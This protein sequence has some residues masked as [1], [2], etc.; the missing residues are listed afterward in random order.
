[1]SI[2]SLKKV[3]LV[4]IAQEKEQIATDLQTKL[5]CMHVATLSQA[6]K[7]KAL[8]KFSL[9]NDNKKAIRYL[10]TAEKKDE[11]IWDREHFDKDQILAEIK[12]NQDDIKRLAQERKE[13]LKQVEIASHW[14]EFTFPSKEE[15]EGYQLWFYRVAHGVVDKI[16]EGIIW[17]AVYEDDAGYYVVVLS[18]DEPCTHTMPVKRTDLGEKPLAELRAELANIENQ[19]EEQHNKHTEL[20]KWEAMLNIDI[21]VIEDADDMSKAIRESLILEDIFALQGWVIKEDVVKVEKFAEEKGLVFMVEEPTWRDNPPT[22]LKNNDKLSVG[23]DLVSF[24][25]TPNYKE[26]DPSITV[27]FSFAFFF[28]MIMADAGYGLVIGLIMAWKWKA[29]GGSAIGKRLRMLGVV[30]SASC[31]AYGAVVGSYFGAMPDLAMFKAM[32]LLEPMNK[33]AM[34]MLAILTGM[35]HIAFANL[36]AAKA[37]GFNR[38]SSLGLLGWVVFIIGGCGLYIG[39]S[40]DI[41]LGIDLFGISAYQK[42]FMMVGGLGLGMILFF[43]STRPF[44]S[45]GNIL[46]RIFDGIVGLTGLSKVFGDILSYLRLFALGLSSAMLASTFN[47][48]AGSAMDGVPVVGVVIAVVVLVAGHS[49]SFV[50][51]IM[52][53]LVHGLRLSLL[54]FFG[55]S[56]KDEGRQFKPFMSKESLLWNKK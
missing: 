11:L 8:E 28:A 22:L 43:T 46:M 51:G 15:L 12:Q 56:L 3:T 27:L 30:L 16:H 38:L 52:G 5:G 20:T 10:H 33:E 37:H 26:W 6:K 32:K 29:M 45:V 1:M 14:G 4:G 41:G 17:E 36:M 7:E 23:E 25:Q 50:L 54:E 35:S 13:L 48:L 40:E 34:I 53:G 31:M 47:D 2:V 19:I 49:I 24:Y 44:N 9:I 18:K 21:A 55:W 42:Q 39:I